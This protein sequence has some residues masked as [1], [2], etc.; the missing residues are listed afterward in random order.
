MLRL[1]K[2]F[3]FRYFLQLIIAGVFI[4]SAWFKLAPI[5]PFELTLVDSGLIP[6]SLAPYAAR[7][8]LSMEVIIG[9]ALLVNTRFTIYFLKAA[10][11]LTLFFCIYLLLL[12][13]FRGNDINCGCFGTSLSLTPLESLVKNALLILINLGALRLYSKNTYSLKWA[14]VVGGISLLIAPFVLN[15]VDGYFSRPDNT[16]YPYPLKTE[17]IPDTIIDKLPYDLRQGEHLLAFLSVTCPHCK[18]AAKKISVAQNQYELPP[19]L[20][21]FIGEPSKMENFKFESG[22]NLPYLMY[23]ENSFFKF[24]NGVLPTMLL[25]KDGQVIKRWTGS[26]FSYEEIERIPDYLRQV[27]E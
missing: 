14:Y 24:N 10:L 25:V 1:S 12:W 9:V 27:E 16:E 19:V 15:P 13:Y 20:A 3:I 18:V 17:I 22:S 6:W 23:R 5:E 7:L 4:A 8:L 2:K 21:F 11:Y 26:S